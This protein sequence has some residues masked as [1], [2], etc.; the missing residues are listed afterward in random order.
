MICACEAFVLSQAD[1]E[2]VQQRSNHV[3]LGQAC[4]HLEGQDEGI[5]RQQAPRQEWGYVLEGYGKA[6][7]T[8]DVY[9]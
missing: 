5:V 7:L 8:A 3:D 6:L 9:F 2:P 4:H 1:S